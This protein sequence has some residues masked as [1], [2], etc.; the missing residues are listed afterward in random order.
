MTKRPNYAE[1]VAQA[2]KA[3]VGVTDQE[4]KRIAFQRVLDDLRASTSLSLL[5]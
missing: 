3:V 4:S 1:L 2:E 5:D